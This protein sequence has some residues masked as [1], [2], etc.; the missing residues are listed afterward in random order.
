[1]LER[2]KGRLRAWLDGTQAPQTGP[3]WFARLYESAEAEKITSVVANKLA[4]LTFADSTLEVSGENSRAA[5][6]RDVLRQVWDMGIPLAAQALGKGGKVVLPVVR[7]GKIS[8]RAIDQSRMAIR[9]TEGGRPVDVTI[10][11]DK[12]DV[13]GKQYYL[14]ADYAMQADGRQRIGYRACDSDGAPMSLKAV[15]AWRG[16]TQEMFVS[17]TDRL[18]LGYLR[19]PRDD[20]TEKDGHGVPVT[21]GAEED[22]AELVEHM[23]IYRREFKLS[24]MM[25]GLDSGLWRDPA[26]GGALPADISAVRKTVQDGDDPFIP[27]DAPTLEGRS[28]WQVYAPPIRH[29]AMEARYNSLCR[30][31]EMDCGLSRGILTERQRISYANRDEIRAAMYDTFCMV[32]AV[33]NA[34][35]RMLED[36]AC[37]VDVL[38]DMC[39]IAPAGEWKIRADWD[40]GLL[41][42][43]EQSFGQN[44]TLYENGLMSGAELRQWA[45]GGTMQAAQADVARMAQ[46][47][48][49]QEKEE[50]G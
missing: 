13:S 4:M 21:Y 40:Y 26:S 38:A 44:L 33:R 43:T 23:R 8:V 6:V 22:I 1:M 30:R 29:E 12:A 20:R 7:D 36:V 2:V 24:R 42:S 15:E 32:R 17:G 48:K 37:A 45:L 16:L 25:L 10:L 31:I 34:F 18:L 9:R 19:C 35:E 11:L 50:I 14:L 3:E 46:A 27:W 39:G 49:M 5:L 28:A 41:E 47:E